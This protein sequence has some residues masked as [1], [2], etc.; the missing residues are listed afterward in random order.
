VNNINAIILA[1]GKGTRMNSTKPKVLQVLSDK[2]L[3]E[4]V[5]MQAQALCSQVFV[6]VGL[7][8]EQVCQ[9][10]D[11]DSINWV[12]QSEQLGTGH[13]VQQAT[14]YINDDSISLVLY[15][16]VPLIRQSTLKDL[17][18][19]AQKSGVA[20]LSVMLDNPAGYGRI[21][22]KD[23]QIQ[24]IVEQKDANTEQLMICEV[25]TGIMVLDSGLLK[26]YLGNLNANNAQGEFYLTDIKRFLLYNSVQLSC[27]LQAKHHP[28]PP[29]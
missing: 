12:E 15:G 9:A 22:R 2:T 23:N 28:Q 4:H 1:A 6:V 18:T 29:H 7:G 11:D 25:N 5:L 10:L 16:D 8:S 26:A 19:Q 20:L 14:P 3:L 24:A 13:A 17:I 21:I 27:Y